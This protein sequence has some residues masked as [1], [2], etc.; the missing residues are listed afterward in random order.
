RRVLAIDDEPF[1]LSSLG[2]ILG[3]THEV[4]PATDGTRAITLLAED[5]QFD[6]ILCDLMMHGMDGIGVYDA[7]QRLH[8][9][10]ERRIVFMTGGVFSPRV[11]T[12]LGS[13]ENRCLDK[14]FDEDG[15]RQAVER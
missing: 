9:G 2:L 15:L 10:L 7:V 3:D 1:I 12:F 4:V 6:V 14:P 8:P 13:V 11:R 5:A